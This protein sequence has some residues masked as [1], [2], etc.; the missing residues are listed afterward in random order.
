MYHFES[1]QTFVLALSLTVVIV[2]CIERAAADT[3]GSGANTFD[4]EFVPIGNPG[5]VADTTG[6]PNPAGSVSYT[7]R[8]ATFTDG[9]SGIFVSNRVAVP[10]PSAL[11]LLCFGSLAALWCRRT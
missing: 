9:T 7:Y 8:M 3:F 2:I 6:S 4:I 10:E 5:N 1:R 11:L